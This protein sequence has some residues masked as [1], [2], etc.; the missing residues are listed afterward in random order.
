MKELYIKDLS[1]NNEVLKCIYH[2]KQ[3][4]D[5]DGLLELYSVDNFK[6]FVTVALAAEEI[7]SHSYNPASKS[8]DIFYKCN[9]IKPGEV[10]LS[11]KQG[12]EIPKDA[13]EINIYDTGKK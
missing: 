12:I 1:G 13:K 8:L 2:G 7:G 9:P 5:L 4:L 6:F 11:I 10:R 3:N